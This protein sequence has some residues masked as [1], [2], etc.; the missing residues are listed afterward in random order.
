MQ[1]YKVKK[2]LKSKTHMGHEEILMSRPALTQAKCV[3]YAIQDMLKK[4]Y[5]SIS[6]DTE[7]SKSNIAMNNSVFRSAV[8]TYICSM[9]YQVYSKQPLKS[10]R[11]GKIFTI[12]T[13]FVNKAK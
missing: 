12:L 5:T 8:C 4:W 11:S 7:G 10:L 6:A 9:N 1:K 3:I 2:S 13:K